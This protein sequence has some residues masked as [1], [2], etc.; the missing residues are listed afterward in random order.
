M[1]QLSRAQEQSAFRA[2]ACPDSRTLQMEATSSQ[3][4]QAPPLPLG[5]VTASQSNRSA[6]CTMGPGF[7]GLSNCGWK[8]EVMQR[9]VLG[10]LGAAKLGSH[11]G[12]TEQQPVTAYV[13][14]CS[15]VVRKK[16]TLQFGGGWNY[17]SRLST[18][19]MLEHKQL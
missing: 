2:D 14:E 1:Q 9:Q 6:W 18:I 12:V 10:Q 4:L 17:E 5:L 11:T 15:R 8:E 13:Q 16:G 3:L 7:G 19:L